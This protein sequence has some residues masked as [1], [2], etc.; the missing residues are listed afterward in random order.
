VSKKKPKTPLPQLDPDYSL[1]DTHC[2]LDMGAY[3]EDLGDILSNAYSSGV[4]AIV[5]IGIDISS[6]QEAVRLAKK[7]RMIKATAGIH[8]H[9]VG[10]IDASDLNE[11][12]TLI[13]KNH[14]H[15]VGYG[16]IGLDY[17]KNYS[18]P[19]IQRHYFKL[20][21]E[22][23]REHKLPVIIHDRDAHD[24]ILR[25]TKD[26]A[27]FPNGGIMHCFSGNME[28][29]KE[30]LD[31]GLLISIPGIVT[32]KKAT[33]LQE[34]AKK[35]PLDSILLET[36]GPFLAPIPY[37]GKRNEPAYLLYTLAEVAKLRNCS[38]EEIAQATTDNA[39]RLFNMNIGQ[40]Q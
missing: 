33:D 1:I 32:F 28:Y 20:Q 14:Q 37:R 8:P 30:I 39:C 24:D 18:E 19:D 9:D 5:T 38:L 21:L 29:A 15:I 13:E 4:H 31:L 34:V 27:P 10:N 12:Q 11:I 26:C 40:E 2:H 25:I 22:I 36:D 7:Y 16:E 35:I 17:V 3:Q 6:S 23:A